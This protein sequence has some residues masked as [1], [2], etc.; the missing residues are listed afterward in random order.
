MNLSL[1]TAQKLKQLQNGERLPLSS[2]RNAMAIV[3]PMIEAGILIKQVQGRSKAVIYL[4]DPRALEY[5]LRNHYGIGQLDVYIEA[6]QKENLTRPEAVEA[7][8]DSKLRT[9]RTFKGFLVNC[10]QPL[11]CILNGAPYTLQP[12]PGVFTFVYDFETFIPP[13]GVTVVGIENPYNFR[14]IEKQ[15]ALF[16]GLHPLFVSRYPQTKDLIQWLQQISNPYLHFGDFDFAGLNIYFHSFKAS[17]DARARFFVPPGIDQLLAIMGNR[18]LY[19]NQQLQFEEKNIT[20]PAIQSLLSLLHQHKKG[21]EQ[22]AF[23]INKS[24]K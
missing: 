14:Y 22:E 1:T 23:L 5:F 13:S 16:G 8:S 19:H 15:A 18:N 10:L 6:L 7:A 3:T 11:A 21:L 17:L 4:S 2:F 12:Q 20:E 24:S 9:S